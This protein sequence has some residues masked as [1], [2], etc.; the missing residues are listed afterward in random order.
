MP[1]QLRDRRAVMECKISRH[2]ATTK[3]CSGDTSQ[4][5]Q[6]A[7]GS[8][9]A[10]NHKSPASYRSVTKFTV[11]SHIASKMRRPHFQPGR[12][13]PWTCRHR[14][15]QP[16]LPPPT[17]RPSYPRCSPA[18]YATPSP[19]PCPS[20]RTTVTKPATRSGSPRRSCSTRSIRA[21]RPR[22][23]LSPSRSP[24][25]WRRWTVSPVPPAPAPPT[26]PRPA[27]AAVRWPPAAPMPGG[28]TRSANASPPRSRSNRPP[29][30]RPGP[31]RRPP[32]PSPRCRRCHRASSR[33]GPAPSR[34]RRS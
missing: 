12:R 9:P 10:S 13:H 8:L 5:E 4:V 7:P 1:W 23:S 21:I 26:R 28:C 17:P 22:P 20:A 6:G 2:A 34:S 16:P 18:M 33:S 3:S 24:H 27:C 25:P 14:T 30:R 31:G 11:C 29:L 19:T 15:T 32:N